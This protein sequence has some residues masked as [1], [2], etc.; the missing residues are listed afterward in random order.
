[1]HSK[2]PKKS[3][4][5]L[6]RVQ[7]WVQQ[8]HL[9]LLLQKYQL[10]LWLL[11]PFPLPPLHAAVPKPACAGC[12]SSHPFLSA[13]VKIAALSVVAAAVAAA[14]AAPAF[15]VASSAIT[16]AVS[17]LWFY[18][19]TSGIVPGAL[20]AASLAACRDPAAPVRQA[21]FF[22]VWL[23]LQFLLQLPLLLLQVGRKSA[24]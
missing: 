8:S 12:G 20:A 1:M 5:P 16:A 23:L 6:G 19:V 18:G 4:R 2:P 14:A 9:G 3:C 17:V 24:N 13:G 7:P 11:L 15:G 22:L 10:L 21:R